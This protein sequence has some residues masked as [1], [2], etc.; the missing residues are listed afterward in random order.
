[1]TSTIDLRVLS[2]NLFHGRDSPPDPSLFTIRSRLLRKTEDNGVFLQLNRP[3]SEEFASMI[4]QADWSLCL[5]QETPPAWRGTLARH[6]GARA[7]RVLTSRN[8]LRPLTSALARWNPDLIASWE[9]GSNLTLVR[10]PWRI[11]DRGCRS[12][13][14][15][16]LRER[17]LVER[18]RMSFT[19]VRL[20]GD[21]TEVCVANLHASSRPRTQ[22]ER[23]LLLAARTGLAWAGGAPIVLGGDFN[24]RPTGAPAL[25]DRLERELGFS[26]PTAPDAI[27]HLLVRGLDVS[28]PPARWA[29]ERRELELR[30][31]AGTRKVR[32]S[33]HAPVEGLFA[34]RR[35]RCDTTGV[36]G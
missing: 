13:L 36:D 35:S 16:P 27:D 25:Y 20:D 34:L 32:L 5:L 31:D 33:D 12:L 2:W 14:L 19:R 11:V 8:Q 15:N 3:L 30:A 23:E 21:A 17:R 1:M 29:V 26:P 9:G 22:T 18:R 28:R 10:P 24:L 4:A 7:C 6:C